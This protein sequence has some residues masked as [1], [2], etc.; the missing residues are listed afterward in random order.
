[1]KQL[2][3]LKVNGK[4]REIYVEPWLSL[5]DVLRDELNLK[6]VKMGCGEGECGWC[7]VLVDGK[8]VRSCL[9]LAFQTGDREIETVEG[10]SDG[11][12]LHPLQ[13]AFIDHF[14][15]QCGYCTPS[16]ILAAKALLD[17]NPNPTED[18]IKTE[19]AGNICRC[20]GYK[21]IVEAI[22]AAAGG[23]VNGV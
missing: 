10:L 15:V 8:A 22:Q 9:M 17:E 16:M 13:Q 18:E 3:T 5:A 6:S 11:T 23:P 12:A 2:L 1:M 19:L 21:K 7:T 4:V 20:T 14:A